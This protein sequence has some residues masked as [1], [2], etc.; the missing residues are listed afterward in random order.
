MWSA[1]SALSL[2]QAV[3]SSHAHIYKYMLFSSS[4][5][6]LPEPTRS[7]S[8][9][10]DPRTWPSLSIR[11]PSWSAS[12]QGTQGPSFPG[13]GLVPIRNLL[14]LY[15]I[16]KIVKLLLNNIRACFNL[17]LTSQTVCVSIR[18]TLHRG[19]GYPG[20]GDRQPD[21][22]RR[23]PAALWCVCVCCQSARHQ[24]EA[25]CTRTTCG[26]RWDCL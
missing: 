22:L 24:N 17:I 9:C 1:P 20:S 7:Q 8:S 14:D 19:G 10:L 4:Q 13:A 23:F 6:Q 18:W 15:G 26:T 3:L 25:Y 5:G 16:D 2:C 11:R 21:D 12:P